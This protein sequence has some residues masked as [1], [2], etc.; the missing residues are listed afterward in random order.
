MTKVVH[1]FARSADRDRRIYPSPSSYRITLPEKIDNVVQL[2]ISTLELPS[3]RT[4]MTVESDVNDRIWFS[5]G[6]KLDLGETDASGSLNKADVDSISGLDMTLNQLCLRDTSILDASAANFIVGVPAYLCPV[7]S[8]DSGTGVITTVDSSANYKCYAAWKATHATA[9]DIRLV[10]H[11]AT[12]DEILDGATMQL[13]VPGDAALFA[14]AFVSCPPLSVEELTSYL[15][16]AF[17]NY[18]TYFGASSLSTQIEFV[19]QKGYVH[20]LGPSSATMTLHFPTTRGAAVAAHYGTQYPE[21]STRTALNGTGQQNTSLGHMLGLLSNQP[22]RTWTRHS[23][24][25]DTRTFHGLQAVTYPRFLFEARLLPG[26]YTQQTLSAALPIAMNPLYFPKL[27]SSPGHCYFGFRDSVGVEKLAIVAPGQYTPE[28]FCRALSYL[29]TRLDSQGLFYSTSAYAYRATPLDGNQIARPSVNL[30]GQVVYNVRYNF[31]TSKFTVEAR[32]TLDAQV[33]DPSGNACTV[34]ETRPGPKFGL[35]FRPSTLSKIAAHVTDL[36]SLVASSNVDRIANVLGFEIQD[37]VGQTSYTAPNASHLPRISSTLSQGASFAVSRPGSLAHNLPSNLGVSSA[38]YG[39]GPQQYMYPSGKYTATGNSPPTSV[40]NLTSG[41]DTGTSLAPQFGKKAVVRTDGLKVTVSNDG[42]LAGDYAI[43]AGSSFYATNTYVV[44]DATYT[45]P[46]RPG[47]VLFQIDDVS[48]NSG[49]AATSLR[50]VHA[51]TGLSAAS[52][53]SF[54]ALTA[55]GPLRKGVRNTSSTDPTCTFSGHQIH[56]STTLLAATTCAPLGYQ[57]GD[58]VQIW[59]AQEGLCLDATTVTTQLTVGYVGP[60]RGIP[61][62]T[63]YA[64]SGGSITTGNHHIVLGGNYD[65]VVQVT[66]DGSGSQVLSVVDSGTQYYAG[67]TYYLSKPIRYH[68]F[69]ALVTQNC[70]AGGQYLDATNSAN[71]QFYSSLPVLSSSTAGVAGRYSDGSVIRARIPSTLL[72]N[73]FS[74]CQSVKQSLPTRTDFHVEDVGKRRDLRQY[75]AHDLVGIG[76]SYISMAENIEF[77]NHMNVAPVPYMLVCFPDLQPFIR[78]QITDNSD[79]S[80]RG[81]VV[82]KVVIGAP[83]AISKTS[84]MSIYLDGASIKRFQIEFRLPDNTS[85]YNFHGVDHTLTLSFVTQQ[86]TR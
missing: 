42:Q 58:L 21:F 62:A 60:D 81:D 20:V 38:P 44:G 35:Y 86:P 36:D 40:L 1:I 41:S 30:A 72:D 53:V 63:T 9:P 79:Y 85:L 74:H 12:Y 31:T 10:C 46:Q 52:D 5:E 67:D 4:H 37:Y 65:A 3:N 76:P 69:T 18:S 50:L 59:C 19:Y 55:Y 71:E 80:T 24:S 28:T 57:V 23:D 25:G 6:L 8:V 39:A 68:S 7:T 83:V 26:I 47:S 2:Q 27:G 14:N 70:N 78:T 11:N 77:P 82:G 51:G 64:P 43:S 73:G 61:A 56:Q 49:S 17:A 48:Y 66:L 33:N 45:S 32:Y 15:T 29:L 22:F 84:P 75:S 34:D 13:R 16:F 54:N